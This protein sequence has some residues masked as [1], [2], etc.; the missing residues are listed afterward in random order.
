MD[1]SAQFPTTRPR[2]QR[3]RGRAEISVALRGGATRLSRLRQE[4]C[5]KAFLPRNPGGP[6]E[7]V[8]VN[9]SGGVA[10]GDRLDWGLAVGPG[11]TL[12]ATTQAAERIYRSTGAVARVATRIDLAPR[13]RLDW[14]PQETILFEGARLHRRIEADLADDARLTLLE[15]VVLGRAAMGETLGA[16]LLADHWRIRRGGRLAR[17]EALRLDDATL[18]AA[19]RAATLA[20]SRAFATLLHVGP[21]VEAR[22]DAVRALLAPAPPVVAAA[23]ARDG[24]LAVRFLAPG[25][26]P[27]K[28]ALVTFLT[29]FRGAP[30]RVWSI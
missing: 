17:A 2:L 5:A 25:H 14:L 12:V 18:A 4:G 27:L 20:A 13:A 8:F 16:V 26:A 24:V 7:S 22:I 21:G 15:T 6:L 28:A 19:G 1:Q 30:P 3:A 29:A 9:T 11:A 23:S 10:G